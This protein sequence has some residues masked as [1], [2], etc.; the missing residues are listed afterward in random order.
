MITFNFDEIKEFIE[1]AEEW[2]FGMCGEKYYTKYRILDN[3]QVQYRNY[4]SMID[5]EEWKDYELK[6]KVME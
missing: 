4:G 6:G 2:H 1:D 5:E 3:G